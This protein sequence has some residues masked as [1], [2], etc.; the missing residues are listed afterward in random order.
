MGERRHIWTIYLHGATRKGRTQSDTVHCRGQQNQLPWRSGHPNCGN[1]GG[2]NAVQQRHLHEG[3]PIHD[4]GHLK[5]LPHDT[6]T[7]SQIHLNKTMQH[8]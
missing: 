7:P 2:K 6:A 3:C 5:L 1:A 8:T 4:N